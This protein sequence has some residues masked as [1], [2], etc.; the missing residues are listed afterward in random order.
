MSIDVTNH[1]LVP[2]HSKATDAEKKKL[3]ADFA[4]N[5]RDLPKMSVSDPAI[6]GL[7]VVAGDV[8]KIERP[9]RTAGVAYY[10]RVVIAE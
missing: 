9:S 3:F 10:Y 7:K 5:E 2:K 8:V 6:A 4:I 1:S